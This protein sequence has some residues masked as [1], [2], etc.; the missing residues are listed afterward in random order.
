MSAKR[1][2]TVLVS[3]SPSWSAMA[4]ASTGLELPA[5]SLMAPF[6]ADI[7]ASPRALLET[8]VSI[9][10]FPWNRPIGLAQRAREYQGERAAGNLR[11]AIS[12]AKMPFL[13]GFG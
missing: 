4:F 8:L 10:G 11:T 7:E 12:W 9:S 1:R 13:A 2:T 6:L 5:T 3:G